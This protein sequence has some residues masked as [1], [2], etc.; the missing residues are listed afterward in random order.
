[1]LSWGIA[2]RIRQYLKGSLWLVPLAG[3]LLGAVAGPICDRAR[4]GLRPPERA[5]STHPGRRRRCSRRSSPHPRRSPGFVVTVSVLVVQIAIDSLSSRYMRLWFRDPM[6]KAAL[7]VLLGTLTFALQNLRR[8]N[9]DFVPDLSVTIAGGLLVLGVLLFLLF[10][11]RA[12]HLVRPV[13]V[14]ARRSQRASARSTEDAARAAASPDRPD[15]VVGEY[16]TDETIRPWS[17]GAPRPA[18][19]RRSTRRASCASRAAHD[20]QIVFLHA[21]GDFISVGAPRVRGLRRERGRYRS[22]SGGSSA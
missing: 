22:S 5:G 18:H 10:L 13:A 17:S 3:A 14:A 8:V 7:A 15:F 6:L 11:D 21:V 19:S 12:L 20:C 2:F 16:R 1:M 4:Y 9:A